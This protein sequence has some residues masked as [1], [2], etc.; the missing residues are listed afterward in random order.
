MMCVCH[1]AQPPA[2]APACSPAPAP[3]QRASPR[4]STRGR[5]LTRAL[6]QADIRLKGFLSLF[7][8]LV[9]G[10]IRALG[11]AAKEGMDRAF[12]EGLHERKP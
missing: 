6:P 7:T 4:S 9:A 3:A 2:W 10:D 5:L 1:Q 8:W 12:A 11:V